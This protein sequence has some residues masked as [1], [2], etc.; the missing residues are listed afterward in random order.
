MTEPPT[1]LS[2]ADFDSIEAAVMETARERWFLAE[3]ARRC[4]AQ[5]TAR[6]LSAVERMEN[7]A[8]AREVGEANARQNAE[9]A[10][11]LVRQLGE[12]LHVAQSSQPPGAQC[13]NAPDPQRDAPA[14]P[15]GSLEARLHALVNFDRLPL[16]Q[17]LKLLG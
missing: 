13:A 8:A 10:E 4:R 14:P 5:D 17:K 6:I 1:G 11:A 2:E 16:A 3:Y 12:I 9:R 15:T 7:A